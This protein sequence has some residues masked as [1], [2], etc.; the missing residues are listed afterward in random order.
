LASILALWLETE[1]FFGASW[2][3]PIA[4]FLMCLATT[5]SMCGL[6]IFLTSLARNE[7]QAFLASVIVGFVLA[8]LG[9]NFFPPGSLPT[10]MQTLSLGTP[11]GWAL[12]GFG[13]LSQEGVNL[14]GVIGPVSVLLIIAAVLGSLSM[15]RI[16]RVVEL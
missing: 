1:L 7:Q 5:L 9:G 15:I 2:G 10:F 6:A 12:V 11:N 8:L 14:S 13:R 3:D 4:V 16:G